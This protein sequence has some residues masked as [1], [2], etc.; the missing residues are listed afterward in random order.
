VCY[1]L[2]IFGN[3]DYH[4]H[5]IIMENVLDPSLGRVGRSRS[6]G[7]KMRCALTIPHHRPNG[8]RSLKIT[9]RNQ[10]SRRFRRCR[11][12]TSPACVRWA[13][14]ANAGLGHAFL[15]MVALWNRADL[16]IGRT[17]IFSCCDL[18]FFLSFFLSF[19]PRLISAVAEWMSAI[20]AHM[21]WP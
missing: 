15:L 3:K 17:I 8:T 14:R 2:Y 1:R 21:V 12:V 9:S 10:Q 5:Q 6:T 16:G 7:T 19:F 20:L 4:L 18:F 13:W 11:G